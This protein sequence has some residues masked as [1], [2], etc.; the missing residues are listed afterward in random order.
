MPKHL[1]LGQMYERL[2]LPVLYAVFPF[3]WDQTEIDYPYCL[4][5]LAEKMPPAYHLACRVN[6]NEELIL[7]DATLDPGLEKLG[8]PVNKNWNGSSNTLLPIIPTGE[9][10]IYH[11]SEVQLT[12]TRNHDEKAGEFYSELNRWLEEVRRS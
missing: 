7:V 1:L 5:K 8:L 12:Q 10:Q 11:P 6:I 3:R 4:R 2:C 9:E